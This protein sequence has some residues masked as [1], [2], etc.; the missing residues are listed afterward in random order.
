M[1]K[2]F[3]R[4]FDPI[5]IS[6]CSFLVA[7][8]SLGYIGYTQYKNLQFI[9][10]SFCGLVEP[11]ANTQPVSPAGITYRDSAAKTTHR[12]GCTPDPTD[13]K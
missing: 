6:V 13:S 1:S 4:A 2:Q 8:S 3:K 7:F 10:E 11:I 5:V 12:L 9:R